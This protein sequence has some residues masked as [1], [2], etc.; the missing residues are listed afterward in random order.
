MPFP[1]LVPAVAP[2][3][4]GPGHNDTLL[5]GL[6]AV[7]CAD[8]A[9]AVPLSRESSGPARR[10]LASHLTRRRRRPAPAAASRAPS[11][12]TRTHHPSGPGE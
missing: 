11:S 3:T 7:L 1:I 9:F 5:W 8:G 2:V 10:L 12:A 4:L 6:A